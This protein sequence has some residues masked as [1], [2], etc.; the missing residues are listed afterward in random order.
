V[1]FR[2]LARQINGNTTQHPCGRIFD[3]LRWIAGE[4][5]HA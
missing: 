2:Q 3:G 4:I 5:C 1:A